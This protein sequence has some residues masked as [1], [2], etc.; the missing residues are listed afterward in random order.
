MMGNRIP[1]AI[2]P[3][4]RT[5]KLEDSLLFPRGSSTLGIEPQE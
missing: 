2:L 5:G 4:V 1:I 3:R